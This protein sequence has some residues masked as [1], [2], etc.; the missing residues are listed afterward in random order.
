MERVAARFVEALRKLAVG[1]HP[2]LEI[3]LVV[4]LALSFGSTMYAWIVLSAEAARI[5]LILFGTITI[6]LLVLLTKAGAVLAIS[7]LIIGTVVTHEDFIVKLAYMFGGGQGRLEDYLERKPEQSHLL[8]ESTSVIVE[9]ASQEFMQKFKQRIDTSTE[10]VLAAQDAETGADP[11]LRDEVRRAVTK[12]SK[13]L[14]QPLQEDLVYMIGSLTFRI[15]IRESLER[16][17]HLYEVVKGLTDFKTL[18]ERYGSLER[19]NFD[20]AALQNED[21][22]VC[23]G[24]DWATCVPTDYAARVIQKMER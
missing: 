2:A 3:A 5:P 23:K 14:E 24:N 4:M 16:H 12:I 21:L 9:Q 22:V 6:A 13:E 15:K 20:M 1:R 19:F 11:E 18:A 17:A 8:P 10:A 7:I